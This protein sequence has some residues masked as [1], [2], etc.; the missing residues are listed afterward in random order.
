MFSYKLATR[1][2]VSLILLSPVA[3][4][5]VLLPSL[6]DVSKAE[7]NDWV[8]IKKA[9]QHTEKAKTFPKKSNSKV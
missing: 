7:R 1:V 9:I 6:N 8:L 3:A 2:A 4:F 5:A